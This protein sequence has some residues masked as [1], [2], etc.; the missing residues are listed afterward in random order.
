MA[1]WFVAVAAAAVA[2]QIPDIN[3]PETWVRV[4]RWLGKRMYHH[5]SLD[6]VARH[7]DPWNCDSPFPSRSD[8]EL[9]ALDLLTTNLKLRDRVSGS[10]AG[11][12]L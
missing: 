5:A 7:N 2:N 4:L 3:T 10:P 6:R 1:V 11:C 8:F 12:V 9:C